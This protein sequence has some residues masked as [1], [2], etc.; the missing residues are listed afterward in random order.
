[1]TPNQNILTTRQQ[2][3]PALAGKVPHF[4]LLFIC[5]LLAL[6][7]YIH[8]L[9]DIAIAAGII[10]LIL[11]SMFLSKW[12]KGIKLEELSPVALFLYRAASLA[13]FMFA[14][15]FLA[16]VILLPILWFMSLL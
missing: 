16:A 12:E 3:I 5:V 15:F 9:S 2:A 1:M 11:D 13:T 4:V 6:K 7:A 14:T 8:P 10:C